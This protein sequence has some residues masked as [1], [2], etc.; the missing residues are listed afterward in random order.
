MADT[1]DDLD[2]EFFPSAGKAWKPSGASTEP[3]S[4][5]DLD[6]QMARRLKSA[7]Q[8]YQSNEP[9]EVKPI[10][11]DAFA[12]STLQLGSLDTKIPL[13]NSTAKGLAQIGSGL[14]D[15]PL[16]L[17]Q[18]LG[19]AG[20]SA[21]F[22]INGI[23]GGRNGRELYLYNSTAQSWTFANESGVDATPANRITTTTG[24]D[25]AQTG[26]SWAFII[27]DSETSRWVLRSV[28]VAAA[29][30]LANPTGTIG[31]AAVNGVA[32]TAMRSDGSPAL[33]QDIAPLWAGHHRFS[34]GFTLVQSGTTTLTSDNTSV[35][36]NGASTRQIASDNAVATSRTF[37]IPPGLFAGQIC[38]LQW[39]G[40]NAGELADD[41]TDGGAAMRLSVS[42]LPTQYDTLTIQYNGT[43]W[44]EL[45]RSTN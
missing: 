21:A 1:L 15:L 33:S 12:G 39:S 5:D 16:G 9:E 26:P 45:A 25:V 20:P 13:P 35:P 23:T 31:L 14:A 4:L 32:V 29:V 11:D 19:K 22:T 30:S 27:Y 3:K 28:T 40:T 43:D 8:T 17:R 41:G 7:Q 36:V 34:N 18:I 44:L 2:K 24:S 6:R 38:I 37:T 42:W 10:S